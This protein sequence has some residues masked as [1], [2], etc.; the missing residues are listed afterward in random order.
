MQ[1]LVSFIT[2]NTFFL[3]S[4][5]NSVENIFMVISIISCNWDSVTFDSV[6]KFAMKPNIILSTFSL[7][8][9]KLIIS[10]SWLTLKVSLKETNSFNNTDYSDTL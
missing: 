4:T 1:T 10:V 7:N 8:G 3:I 2:S 5:I 6:I 9:G